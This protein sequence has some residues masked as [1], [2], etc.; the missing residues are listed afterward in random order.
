MQILAQVSEVTSEQ[1]SEIIYDYE[2][3]SL[4]ERWK[5]NFF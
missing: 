5:S 4:Y 1:P 2:S 3:H